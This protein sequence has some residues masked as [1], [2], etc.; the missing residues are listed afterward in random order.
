MYGEP[1]CLRPR[2]IARTFLSRSDLAKLSIRRSCGALAFDGQR[3]RR[4]LAHELQ[5]IL[6]RHVTRSLLETHPQTE[7][8]IARLKSLIAASAAS[9]QK[10]LPDYSWDDIKKICP[11]PGKAGE[12]VENSL[13]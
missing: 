1:A 6:K 3:R 12:T 4:V 9:S 13:V 7:L 5:H 2:C 8:G 10:L 11:P